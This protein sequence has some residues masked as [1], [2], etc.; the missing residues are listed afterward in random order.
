MV[1]AIEGFLR[2]PKKGVTLQVM[3]KHRSWFIHGSWRLIMSPA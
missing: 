1:V 3:M 2:V